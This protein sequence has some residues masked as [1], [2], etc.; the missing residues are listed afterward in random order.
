MKTTTTLLFALLILICTSAMA[1]VVPVDLS[2]WSALTLDLSGGQ[3]PGNWAL[4]DG[5]T[6]VTQTINADPSFYTNNQNYLEYTMDGTWMV[7]TSSDDDFMGFVFGFQDPNHCYVFDWKARAQN[8]GGYGYAEEG[9][10]LKKIDAPDVSNLTLYDFWESTGT[11]YSTILASNWGSGTGWNDYGLYTFHLSVSEGSFTIT[12]LEDDAILWDVTINDSSYVGGQF[13]F[14]NFSQAHVQYSG[15]TLNIPPVCDA[16]G[17][18]FGDAGVAVQFDG[19]NSIDEDGEIVDWVW[20]FGDGSTGTGETP[21]HT[22]AEDGV[23]EVTLCVTDN[24]GL[25]SCCSATGQ[26]V[27]TENTSLGKMKSIYR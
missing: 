26:A 6:T 12:V 7:N 10:S 4:S 22:Y 2:S 8:A 13:G 19:S 24:E 27:T 1:D 9:M 17:P 25:E 16:G 11:D 21:T 23:Y 5:N 3:P 18:Y 20:D 14:Y 15:F